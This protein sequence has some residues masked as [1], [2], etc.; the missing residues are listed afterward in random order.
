VRPIELPGYHNKILAEG[1]NTLPVNLEEVTL[2]M[3]T[4]AGGWLMYGWLQ[5]EDFDKL[6][7]EEGSKALK[8]WFAQVSCEYAFE[9]NV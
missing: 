2:V 7:E 3:D 6:N 5:Q 1:E 4:Q 8:E 9:V